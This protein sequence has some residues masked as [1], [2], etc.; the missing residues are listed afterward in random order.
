M[1][2]IVLLIVA[3]VCFGLAAWGVPSRV[4]WIGLGL[5]SWVLTV[6]IPLLS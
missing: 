5:L 1:L 2:V 4:N 6:L 3:A